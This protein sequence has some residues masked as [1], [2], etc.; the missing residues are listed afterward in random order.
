MIILVLLVCVLLW[1]V[2]FM[3][4][5]GEMLGREG[6]GVPTIIEMVQLDCLVG[7]AALMRRCVSVALHHITPISISAHTNTRPY[8]YLLIG[9]T[10]SFFWSS[11]FLQ[12]WLPCWECSV[13]ASV[14]IWGPSS[15]IST[16]CIWSCPEPT[17]AHDE[18]I[19]R[20]GMHWVMFLL[21]VYVCW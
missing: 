13:D 11:F 12:T 2:L 18:C 16:L 21:C 10:Y 6:R 19:G 4:A 1:Y 3:R 15:H 8:S 20:Y 7:S 5:N 17:T 14:C 9:F